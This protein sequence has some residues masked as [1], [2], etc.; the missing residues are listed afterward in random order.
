MIRK[1]Q[2]CNLKI[3]PVGHVE[4]VVSDHEFGSPI[5][6][7]KLEEA[8]ENM[9]DS[10]SDDAAA[11]NDNYYNEDDEHYEDDQYSSE[12]GVVSRL[13]FFKKLN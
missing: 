8:E 9:D 11:Y 4:D 1:S 6:F 5:C 7:E 13:S 12:N 10:L 3:K 2:L